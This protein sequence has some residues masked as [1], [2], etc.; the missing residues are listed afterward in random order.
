MHKPKYTKSNYLSN[1]MLSLVVHTEYKGG[2]IAEKIYY[3]R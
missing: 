2:Y 3:P 1:N